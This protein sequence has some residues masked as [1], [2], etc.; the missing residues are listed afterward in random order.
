M[1]LFICFFICFSLNT[2][3]GQK[4]YQNNAFGISLT[5]PA[6]WV[7]SVQK[8]FDGK[9]K[10]SF[11]ERTDLL[12]KEGSIYLASFNQPLR[13]SPGAKIQINAVYKPEKDFEAFK[14]QA[15]ISAEKLKNI[16]N[17]FEFVQEPREI[18][19]A[20]QKSIYFTFNYTMVVNGREMYL[21]NRTYGVPNQN[22]LL[23]ISMVDS[24]DEDCTELFEKFISGL[25]INE[26]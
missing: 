13:L 6:G 12:K 19:I 26:Y 22:F 15:I 1:R 16:L 9:S 20:G 23:H 11:E 10:L 4:T 2:V 14:Q 17:N 25:I 24:P 7:E 5:I 21:R 18:T 3:S 8:G